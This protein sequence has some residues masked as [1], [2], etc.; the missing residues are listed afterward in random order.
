MW[1]SSLSTRNE[2]AS[3]QNTEIKHTN[4]FI[5]QYS[6]MLCEV[7]TGNVFNFLWDQSCGHIFGTL[8][9]KQ[10]IEC[11]L[12]YSRETEGWS[13]LFLLKVEGAQLLKFISVLCS[14]GI[15]H[16]C[17]CFTAICKIWYIKDKTNLFFSFLFFIFLFFFSIL[18]NKRYIT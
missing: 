15:F 17:L 7:K 16:I 4:C 14:L 13:C 6:D 11:S 10:H 12:L 2:S 9:G 8:S 5:R 1:S 3:G 18:Y